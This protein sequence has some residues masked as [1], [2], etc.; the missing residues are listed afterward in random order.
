M[1]IS[2][3]SINMLEGPFFRKILWFTVPLAASGMLQLLFNAA[4]VIV[5]G[6][7][8]GKQALA[9]VSSNGS[10]INL[11]INMFMGLSVGT[12]V[13]CSRFVGAQNSDGV[14]QTVH[15]AIGVSLIGGILLAISGCI[16]ARPLLTLMGSPSD[17][18]E[19]ATLYLRIYFISTPANALY[20][21]GS[22]LLRSVGDTRRPLFCLAVS[23]TLNV[24]L[25]L[26]FV[27]GFHMSVAGVAL[28]SVISQGL[29]A[30]MVVWILIHEQGILHLD[31]YDLHVNHKVL[32]QM[33][34]IGIP[35][36]LQGTL[37]AFSNVV[38]QS[39]VNSFGATVIAGSG[40]AANLER[41]I[42]VAMN[43]CSQACTTFSSQ[44][45]GAQNFRNVDRILGCSLFI[46]LL[47]GGA[48]GLGITSAGPVLLHL[49]S[50]DLAV[51]EAGCLRLSVTSSLYFLAGLMEVTV[52]ALRGL[53]YS[54]MPMLVT[55]LGS[56]VL[57]I[58][59][60][61]FVFPW[62]A[63]VQM[64]FVSFPVAWGI[65]F[66]AHVICFLFVRFKFRDAATT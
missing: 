63:S 64:L 40:A 37:F 16:A 44:N 35:A 27:I 18:I 49:Y 29:A 50:T 31:L 47:I 39:A 51:I 10:L 38:I 24:V 58:V 5:V 32:V 41:F 21:F 7:F 19:L 54:V 48:M 15:T 14:H 23:G 60:V 45:A 36:G 53:G 22:A 3:R 34:R 46:V 9:A 25:N 62:F 43:S 57:R 61:L 30:I 28:A 20:N 56:C 8:A 2:S 6:R 66:L 65:T 11:M 13:L 12:N 55:L 4:D 52:G 59:Y 1:G 33:L 42:Y 26:I 17:V